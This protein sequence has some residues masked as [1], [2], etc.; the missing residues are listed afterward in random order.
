MGRRKSAWGQSEGRQ[1]EDC[2]SVL[3][4]RESWQAVWNGR[5]A[6][7]AC[8]QYIDKKRTIINPSAA[9]ILLL[10]FP[11]EPGKHRKVELVP[12]Q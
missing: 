5:A 3:N 9:F 2:Y 10:F 1:A 4:T 8:L 7:G 6:D 11:L 12:K